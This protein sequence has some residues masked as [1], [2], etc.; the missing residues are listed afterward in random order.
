MAENN[1]T[2]FM[3]L[4]KT[5]HFSEVVSQSKIRISPTLQSDPAP[6][7]STKA[8][9]P[10]DSSTIVAFYN[11]LKP[12]CRRLQRARRMQTT[13]YS[14]STPQYPVQLLVPLL[15]HPFQLLPA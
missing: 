9:H 15:G 14:M 7:F 10:T 2:G 1:L 12:F 5:G 3:V 6:I 8:L 11:S 4:F 13:V